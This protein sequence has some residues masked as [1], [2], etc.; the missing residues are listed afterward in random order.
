MSATETSL[1]ALVAR[2]HS[3][4]AY[5]S[6]PVPEETLRAVFTLAQ[7]APSW[8]NIQ[9]W[10]VWL[11]SGARRATLSER[12]VAAT[13]SSMPAPDLA[14]PGDYPE[15]YATE[16]R[17]CGRALYEAIGVA[18]DDREG[19]ARAWTRNFEAFGAPHVAIVGVHRAFGVYGAIDVGT[20]L[21]HVL[22]AAEAHGVAACAQASLVAYAPVVREVLAIPDEIELLFGIALGYEDVDAA[23]NRCRTTRN[24]ID[25]A[26]TFVE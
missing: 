25:R 8:C 1:A 7:G 14:F 13:Q 26:I 11:A 9:P 16:R 3:V 5:R 22:L 17:E 23:A 24:T 4:R 19:R 20:W 15:P 10:R 18:R 6:E 12:L 2:R 21:G